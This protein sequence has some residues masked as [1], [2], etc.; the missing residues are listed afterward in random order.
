[1]KQQDET[2]ALMM[3]DTYI[4][5]DYNTGLWKTYRTC[6]KINEANQQQNSDASTATGQPQNNSVVI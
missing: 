5:L 3:V 2:V 4:S 1:M 6:R